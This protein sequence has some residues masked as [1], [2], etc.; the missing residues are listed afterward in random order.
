VSA[1]GRLSAF[2]AWAAASTFVF[3]PSCAED[4]ADAGCVPALFLDG[5]VEAGANT[6]LSAEVCFNAACEVAQVSLATEQ[7]CSRLS[8]SS[9]SRVCVGPEDRQRR[10]VAVEIHSIGGELAFQNGDRIA[11]RVRD[12]SGQTLADVERS[13]EYHDV[14][15]NGAACGGPCRSAQLTF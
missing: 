11:L 14:F 10:G 9:D 1:I 3:Q 5:S 8:L 2:L 4:C 7:R 6:S 12:P 13:V 15:P